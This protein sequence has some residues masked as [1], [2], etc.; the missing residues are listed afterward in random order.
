[1]LNCSSNI[2]SVVKLF[3]YAKMATL[4]L[5]YAVSKLS[6]IEGNVSVMNHCVKTIMEAPPDT[7]AEI[8][9][10]LKF[11]RGCYFDAV[12]RENSFYRRLQKRRNTKSITE[13]VLD[14]FR[15]YDQWLVP[16]L[17]FNKESM[18]SIVVAV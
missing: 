18:R 6:K 5:K 10:D 11:K 4:H 7:F 1:M 9:L 3:Q 15:E 16:W 14:R 13:L 8:Q 12:D 2:S 17:Q